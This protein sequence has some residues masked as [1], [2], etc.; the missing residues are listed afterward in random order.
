MVVLLS[1]L[2]SKPRFAATRFRSAGYVMAPSSPRL[3]CRSRAIR[4]SRGRRSRLIS[5]LCYRT[6]AVGNGHVTAR[7]RC[8]LHGYASSAHAASRSAV[9]LIWRRRF[10]QPA[11]VY[12]LCVAMAMIS[13]VMPIWLMAEVSAHRRQPGRHDLGDR[14]SADHVLAG[15]SRERTPAIAAP[16]WCS[17]ACSWSA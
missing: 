7:R 6:T 5:A 1:A 14:P 11:K 2:F 9:F 4:E 3:A 10:D 12:W 13:T 15:Q 8:A 16:P 17:Q